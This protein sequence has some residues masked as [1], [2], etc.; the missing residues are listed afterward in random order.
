MNNQLAD[1]LG[2]LIALSFPA[3]WMVAFSY[4]L[5]NGKPWMVS[6]WVWLIPASIL[7][8]ILSYS[9]SPTP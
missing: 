9:F 1:L 7:L 4:L 5:K 3:L 8:A 6:F 2:I